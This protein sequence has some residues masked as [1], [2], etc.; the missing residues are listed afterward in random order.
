LGDERS[1]V[2]DLVAPLAS[3]LSSGDADEFMARIPEDCPNRAQL[4]DN[5][6]GLIA[7]AE[8]TCSVDLAGVEKDRAD[9]DWLMDIRARATQTLL[10]RRKG[11][12]AI[13]IRDRAISSIAPVSFFRPAA[14]P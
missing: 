7:Q 13:T 6:R 11:K 12:V 4:S 8:I 3:A 5:V 9:L 10:E 14:I 2:L 1:D